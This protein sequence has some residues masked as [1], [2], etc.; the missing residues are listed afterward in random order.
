MAKTAAVIRKPGIGAQALQFAAQGDNSPQVIPKTSRRG[1]VPQEGLKRV[2]GLVPD[3]D[4]RL[5][6]N[7]RKDLHRKLK[8]AA[9]DRGITAGEIIEYLIEHH[10]KG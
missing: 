3:G 7:V 6:V 9:I 2:S 1:K 4:T 5:T 10:L 8:I